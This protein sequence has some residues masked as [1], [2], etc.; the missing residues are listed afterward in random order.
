MKNMELKDIK[1]KK[2]E[3]EIFVFIYYYLNTR[4][5]LLSKHEIFFINT[6]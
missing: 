3:C 1:L 6:I 5:F 2:L 4:F